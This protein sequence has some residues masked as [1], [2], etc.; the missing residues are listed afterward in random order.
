MI[1]LED[2]IDR[3]EQ[4]KEQSK[5]LKNK[6]VQEADNSSDKWKPDTIDDYIVPEFKIVESKAKGAEAKRR[7]VLSK[8]LT[9]VH[10]ARKRR[11]SN[12]CTIMPIA[13]TSNENLSIWGS[14]KNISRAVDKM[15]EIGL[16]GEHNEEY[17]FNAPFPY[18]DENRCKTYK[19]YYENELKF[20]EYCQAH[21]I[22]E[23][24]P[25]NIKQITK[26][27]EEKITVGSFFYTF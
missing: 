22:N 26:K 17:R 1:S 21:N 6:V 19:Y 13:V 10:F 23:Y 9:F 27:E 24:V 18:D 12:A 15:I 7:D 14:E 5:K 20:I 2:I 4:Q 3:I 25:K 11:A 8:I 16:I